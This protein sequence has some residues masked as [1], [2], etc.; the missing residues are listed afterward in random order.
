MA[1]GQAEA[2]DSRLPFAVRLVLAGLG[3]A[4][5]AWLMWTAVGVHLERACVLLDTPYLPLCDDPA[6][7]RGAQRQQQ[8][9]HRLAVN[10]AEA[11][12]W[13]QLTHIETG[14]YEKP[15]LRAV[16]ALAP[17]DPNVL[18]WRAGDLLARNQGPQAV[19]LLVQLVV[20]RKRGEATDA[21]ARIL[22]SGQGTALLRPHLATGDR[23]LPQVLTRLTA[24][25]LPLPP[26]LPL[27]A[28]A[29]SS[30]TIRKPT[31]QFF[32]R[33][34]R[35]AG[36]WS[37][38]YS[39][40]LAQQRGPTPLLHNGRFEQAFEPDGF[41]W[42]TT[43]TLPS[44]AGAIVSQRTSGSRG[45]VLDIEFTGRPLAIPVIRQYVFAPPGKY[46]LR[47]Q[48]M[49]SKLR[50]EEGLAWAARCTNGDAA[51][52]AGRSEGL[53][54]TAGSWQGFQF[55]IS[56]PASCGLVFSLQLETS[57]PSAASAGAKGRAAFDSLELVRQGV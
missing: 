15:L 25:K 13:I 17:N 16:S 32:I 43:P 46:L 57:A 40:W 11:D 19:D 27:M 48:Y 26:A 2:P 38:A 34:L 31:I 56:V 49:S 24:L 37:D 44:K 21:L 35:D 12:S 4:A 47:G 29:S 42:E 41:D 20:Y 33:A 22:A 36:L 7:A 9:R 30:G 10:P 8:L 18:L 5:A 45:Q 28:E 54:D 1:L 14:T 23:W 6:D 50:L 3:I 53:P 55:A 52:P 51:V 39:L